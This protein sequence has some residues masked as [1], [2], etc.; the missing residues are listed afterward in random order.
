VA[1]YGL[2]PGDWQKLFEAQGGK[3]FICQRFKAKAVDHDHACCS[4]PTSCGRC[5]RG[6]LCGTCN[7]G[8]GRWRDD[9]ATFLRAVDYLN[10]P[11][12]RRVLGDGGTD[13]YPAVQA[14]DG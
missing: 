11:P 10:N 8:I 5:V 6:L 7:T 9:V 14:V 13:E 1:T 4:G 2:S 3:C 12:A